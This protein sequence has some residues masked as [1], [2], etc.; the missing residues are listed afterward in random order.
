[1]TLVLVG[2]LATT[3]GLVWARRRW[4]VVTVVGQSMLPTL[5]DGQRILARRPRRRQAFAAGDVV[6]FSLPEPLAHEARANRDVGYRVKRIAAA[7]GEA[8]P[9][10]FA[11]SAM[12]SARVPPHQFVVHGDAAG[13][14]DSRH[15]GLVA[16]AQILAW[17]PGFGG[18]R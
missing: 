2:L 17:L 7:A 9:P 1:M 5:R 3:A 6:V 4:L 15:L 11:S 12:G 14:E 8:L 18:P 10:W 16:R 13:S